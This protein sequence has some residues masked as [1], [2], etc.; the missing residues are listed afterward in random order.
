MSASNHLPPHTPV[1][2]TEEDVKTARDVVSSS[3]GN[4]PNLVILPV[5]T[6]EQLNPGLAARLREAGEDVPV[7]THVDG[8]DEPVK[9][10]D[11]NK[12]KVERAEPLRAIYFQMLKFGLSETT[13]VGRENV[14]TRPAD[15]PA[16]MYGIKNAKFFFATHP[17]LVAN[18]LYTVRLMES[19][20]CRVTQKIY[21]EHNAKIGWLL[22]EVSRQRPSASCQMRLQLIGADGKPIAFSSSLIFGRER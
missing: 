18:E 20:R 7:P 17:T 12:K 13:T 16:W 4:L 6:V 21:T 2:V 14:P 8:D 22:V 11:L 1:Y 10:I 9:H 19:G 3:T 5:E 15:A